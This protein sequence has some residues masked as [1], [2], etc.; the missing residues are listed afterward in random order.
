MRNNKIKKT[1]FTFAEYNI[2][3]EFQM[4]ANNE[5]KKNIELPSKSQ[6]Q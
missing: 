6:S 3:F 2:Y 5:K 1:P 4:S